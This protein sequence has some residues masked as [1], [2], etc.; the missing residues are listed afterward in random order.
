M[1]ES[2]KAVIRAFIQDVLNQGRFD[3]AD[4]LVKQDFI[5]LDPFPGQQQ[6]R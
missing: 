3:R 4:D 2:N 1:S 6:G 5:E